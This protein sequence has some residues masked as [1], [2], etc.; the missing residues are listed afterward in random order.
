MGKWDALVER[1]KQQIPSVKAILDETWTALSL[2][3]DFIVI[4]FGEALQHID[5]Q[6]R[7]IYCR[8][9][10]KALEFVAQGWLEARR[11]RIRDELMALLQEQGWEAF[12]K[13]AT[14]L[15]MDFAE[16]VQKLEKDLG[17]MR[18]VRGGVTFE[19]AVERLLKTIGIP[20]ERPR[21]REERRKLEHID[22]VIPDVAT[23]LNI[24]DSAVFLALKRTLRERWKQEVPAAQS[25]KCWLKP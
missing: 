21:K 10:R 22:L 1:A 7:T 5:K 24:P 9:E 3:D 16:L 2:S 15:F 20:C 23:A 14:A 18:K 8:Y 17:N 19:R 11:G 6:A 12:K 4:A 25:R 13:R